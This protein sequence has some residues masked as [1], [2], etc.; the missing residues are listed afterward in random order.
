MI[1]YLSFF[2]GLNVCIYENDERLNVFCKENIKK[3]LSLIEG[4]SKEK[5]KMIVSIGGID[6]QENN[7]NNS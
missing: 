2:F 5:Q 4:R 7:M 6:N 3:N 1:E